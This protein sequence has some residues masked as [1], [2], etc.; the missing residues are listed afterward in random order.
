MNAKKFCLCYILVI[1]LIFCVLVPTFVVA[2]AIDYQG[3]AESVQRP[4]LLDST[5]QNLENITYRTIKDFPN[6]RKLILI[7]HS[8]NEES[9]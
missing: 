9:I 4:D 5:V 3:L 7:I 2:K 1:V 6:G 8:H